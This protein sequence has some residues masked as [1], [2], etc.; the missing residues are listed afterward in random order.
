MALASPPVSRTMAAAPF[1]IGR[2][3]L[4]HEHRLAAFE[5]RDRDGG[6]QPRRHRDRDR[7]DIAPPDHLCPVA[8][9]IGDLR[10]ARQLGRPCCVR[11][12]QRHNPAARIRAERGQLHRAPVVAADN[13]KTDQERSLRPVRPNLSGQKPCPAKRAQSVRRTRA[14][15]GTASTTPRRGDTVRSGFSRCPDLPSPDSGLT[16][17]AA[18]RVAALVL[19]ALALRLPINDL[20]RYGVLLIGSIAIFSSA[21]RLAPA[22]WLAAFAVLAVS[23]AAPWLWPAPRIE[24]GHN[25]FIAD[26]GRAGALERGLPAE[27]FHQMLAEFDARYPREKRCTADTSGCWRSEV[28]ARAYAFSADAI[29]SGAE[30]SRRVTR[31]D[32]SDPVWQRLGFINEGYNWYGASDLQRNKREPRWN[33]LHPWAVD[34]AVFRDGALSGRLRRQ[35]VVLARVVALGGRTRAASSRCAAPSWTAARSKRPMPE[36]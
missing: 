26:D 28:P 29:Y 24:E 10:L 15:Q 16:S 2:H 17:S 7:V 34:H 25:V 19:V 22:R 18:L 8:V 9:G 35:P 21:V 30:F 5:R 3:R 36:E 14:G 13:P 20:P 11:S 31:I 32:F 27:A 23:F 4:L 33:L 1:E 6:L 12:R